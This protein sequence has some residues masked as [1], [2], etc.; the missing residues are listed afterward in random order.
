MQNKTILTH[1]RDQ[2]ERR[3][4]QPAV[5]DTA[6]L[7][8]RDEEA[9]AE[10]VALDDA[11]GLAKDGLDLAGLTVAV[12]ACFDVQGWVTDAASPVL[13]SR[14]PASRDAAIVGQ[15][16]AA[17]AIVVGHAN[18]TEFAFGA[19]GTNPH[20]GTPLTPLD[21]GAERIAGGSTSGGAVA[22]AADFADVALGSDTSGSVR[23]P[24]A[25]CGVVGF[26]PSRGRYA[27]EGLVLLSPSFDVPGLITRDV[28]TCRRVDHVLSP[29]ELRP[30]VDLRGARFLIPSLATAG[31]VEEVTWLFEQA[32]ELLQSRGA[33][34]S[35]LNLPAL[36]TYGQIAAEGGIIIAEAF[37]YHRQLLAEEASEYDPRVGPR[38]ALGENVKAWNYIAAQDQLAKLAQEFQNVVEGVDALLMPT[39]P[40]LPPKLSDLGDDDVYY[41]LNRQSFRLTEIANRV[42]SPSISIPIG[43][44]NP[45]GLMLTSQRGRDAALLDLA[46]SVEAAIRN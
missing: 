43:T 34:I 13:A 16:R 9:L 29:E 35:R 27:T 5:R 4:S 46:E 1:L 8:S 33:T 32:V 22:V 21:K 19:L 45:V 6:L 30:P 3:D 2:F 20:F 7:R 28:A 10:A 24:A 39:V 25:F 36:E 23:I 37:A 44:G 26:K 18:M 14:E 15:L 41:A 40:F 12:K 17:G 11:G 31:T 38:I 42:D